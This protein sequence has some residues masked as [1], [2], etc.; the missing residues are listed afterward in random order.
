M[1][2]EEGKKS[3]KGL[4][5]AIIAVLVAAAAG[6]TLWLILKD[7]TSS[8]V[9]DGMKIYWNV[10]REQY[11]AKGVDGVS[12]RYPRED[13]YYYVRFAVDGEQ[14]D[15]PVESLELVNHVDSLEYM[16]LELND[17][18]V[19]VGVYDVA[20]FTGGLAA[21]HYYVESVDGTS[22][23][24]NTSGTLRGVSVEL[25]VPEGTPIYNVGES[26]LLCGMATE[27][28]NVDDEI[29]AIKDT[30]GEI[31]MV[32]VI[33][34]S[35]PGPIY[36]NVNRMYDSATSSTARESDVLGYYTFEMA[37]GGEIVSLRTQDRSVATAI[38]R[39]AARCTALVFDEAGLIIGTRATGQETGGTAVM[40]WFHVISIDGDTITGEKIA[41]GSDQGQVA[42]YRMTQYTQVVLTTTGE[43]TQP[44]V[45]DQIHCLTDARGNLAYVFIISRLSDTA[46]IG[47]N[48]ERQYDSANKVTSRTPDAEGYYHITVASEG[49]QLKLKTKDQSLATKVDAYAAKCFAFDYEGDILTG[50]YSTGVVTGGGV[51]QSWYNLDSV[52]ENGNVTATKRGDT[53][54]AEYG[55]TVTKK[56]SE[57]CRI[58][59]V[60]STADMVG[61]ETELQ[62]GDMIHCLTNLQGEIHTIFVVTRPIDIPIYWNVTRMYNS[63]TKQTTRVPDAD[64]YYVFEMCT[65]G[66][67]V[68]VKTQSK[69]IATKIDSN[70]AK[71]WGL[72]V[73]DGIVWEVYSLSNVTDT[74]GGAQVSWCNITRVTKYSA[75]AI[76]N[77]SGSD[78]G[79]TYTI[80]YAYGCK[81][82]DVSNDYEVER[83]EETE[84]RVG[85]LVH[86]L[87]N[88]QGLTT[89]VWIISRGPE[90]GYM[91]YC[92]MC[93]KE[94]LWSAWDGTESLAAGVHYYL[95]DDVHL[96]TY[97]TTSGGKISL[98][99]NGHTLSSDSRA[100]RLNSSTTLNIYDSME[101]GSDIGGK[102][103]GKGLTTEEA[104][105]EQKGTSEGGVIILWGTNTLNLYSGTVELAEDHNTVHS[106]GVLGGNGT[107]N[108]YGGKLTGGEVT[109]SGGTIRRYGANTVTNIYGGVIDG[110][111]AGGSGGSISIGGA[112]NTLNIYGGTF[113]GGTAKGAGDDI[114]I[115]NGTNLTLGGK[116]NLSDVHINGTATVEDLEEGTSIGVTCGDINTPFATLT[117]AD[118]AQYFKSNDKY[119]DVKAEGNDLYLVSNLEEHIHC[120]CAGTAKGVGNHTACEDIEWTPWTSA[121]SLPTTSGNYYLVEDVT[122]AGFTTSNDI[123]I[124]LCLNGHTVTLTSPIWLRGDYA[125]T[126]C[127]GSG[128]IYGTRSGHSSIFYTY[129]LSNLYLYAGTL[130]GEKASGVNWGVVSMCDDDRDGD[131]VRER[132]Y[133][134]MYGGK[135]V[136]R[137]ATGQISGAVRLM[138]STTFYMYGGTIQGG[139]AAKGSA[140][141]AENTVSE[142]YLLGGTIT[143]GKSDVG[144]IYMGGGKLTI[145]G[146]VQ[147]T[148]NTKSD[149][150]TPSNVY[151]TENL[152]FDLS[153]LGSNAK[154][155]ITMA[156]PGVF[157][158]DVSDLTKQIT[159]DDELYEVV[160]ENKML[161]LESSVPPHVHCLCNGNA[162]GEGD[163]SSCSNVTWTAWTST[164]SLPSASGNY[165]L[166]GDVT[167]TTGVRISNCTINICLNG[168]DIT[169]ESR[170]YRMGAN[171]NLSFTDH[172]L[173]GGTYGGTVSGMGLKN[174]EIAGD[175]NG[176]ATEGGVIMQYNT[177]T[178]LNI[179][180]GNYEYTA[181]TD[182]RTIVKNGGIFQGGG[183]LR[184][185]DGVLTGGK[186]SGSGGALRTWGATAK[187]YLYGGTIK[188]GNAGGSG[189]NI[190]M[191]SNKAGAQLYIGDVTVTGGS[192]S[193][194]GGI[195]L[196]SYVTSITL[197]GTPNITG[198]S[199]GNLYV[200]SSRTLTLDSSLTSKAKVGIQM[201]TLGKFATARTA[202][203]KSIFSSDSGDSIYLDGMDLYMGAVP[204]KHCVCAGNYS[205]TGHSHA[206]VTWLAWN[207]TD[208]LTSGGYYYLTA[209]VTRAAIKVEVDTTITICLN[210]YTIDAGSDRALRIFGDL[211]ITDCSDDQSGTI[212]TARTGLATVFYVQDSAEFNLYGGNLVA[213]GKSSQAGVGAISD[214][215]EAGAHGT[216][217]VMNI[218]GGTIK[219]GNVTGDSGLIAMWNK[220]TLNVYGGKLTNGT[221]GKNGGLVNVGGG[222]T[223]NIYGGE[224][225]NGTANNVGSAIVLAASA[226][227]T[228]SGK[229]VFANNTEEDIWTM[230]TGNI[231]V[232][233]LDSS[234]RIKINMTDERVFANNVTTDL[235][236]CFTSANSAY[237]IVWENN[238]LVFK[239][240]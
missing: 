111:S 127:V 80:D 69:E 137:D 65:G 152:R 5:I 83:G 195:Y 236:G 47:W 30:N 227:L 210:G 142:A 49:Q 175:A 200:P 110:G 170:V 126:D 7:K 211:T 15:I 188:G 204:H 91:D 225:S 118:D 133:F 40:S 191:N 162:K 87:R 112:G 20:Q 78:N 196:E 12:A 29:I 41:S 84:L 167:I 181:P 218:Y 153:D 197:A 116:V 21:D 144:A 121:T 235:S 99:L 115:E 22:V 36:W 6:V 217:G 103:V 32:Y 73:W 62:D 209:N 14:V 158:E 171:S 237:E 219:G 105:A 139:T 226:K 173:A 28:I 168:Y 42:S 180:G 228:I 207:G 17:A 18:G 163:H 50:V 70:A 98:F 86:C 25:T 184:L 58:Y 229:P 53:T 240:K 233:G 151:I 164:T 90:N 76:K 140:I 199:G 77:S 108:M 66:K 138:L 74:A 44:Q 52:D 216:P 179:Y 146:D 97:A 31:F 94:V 1:K 223:M 134:Y 208:T 63:T 119:M 46:K 224:F 156:N 61:E 113:T 95:E 64:G 72:D 51:A 100:I 85:D 33:P 26:G 11:V 183:T 122:T 75:E 182:G 213:T 131:K 35:V 231:T 136:G 59:N 221:C 214:E 104:Q 232:T 215:N 135:I 124:K 222:C 148:G 81:F 114:W 230:G 205:G 129:E 161:A 89:Y 160:Y 177:T 45:G 71:C 39:S 123:D 120:V 234:V 27:K 238:T 189:G 88:S 54:N 79:N 60:A 48:V 24:A 96:D 202:A 172:K 16:G 154:V 206:D 82:Y 220:T 8:K 2:K 57:E 174:S 56:M 92:N 117:N 239:K 193:R 68:T 141:G 9:P 107:F 13:G 23:V 203:D 132:S 149:G 194:V 43:Y 38:D 37:Y 190:S 93:K 187:V 106:G 101:D 55:M 198:N 34:Y 176:N 178:V 4:L 155:G 169:S 165:Y 125:V 157:A 166:T 109:N 201:Q 186:V 128:I 147:I 130:S 150:K 212:T 185:Y 143:G 102:I 159:S 145:G 19:V 67:T 192:A 10:E 3:R